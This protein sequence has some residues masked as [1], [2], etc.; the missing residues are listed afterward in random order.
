MCSHSVVAAQ[1]NHDLGLFVEWIKKAMKC[2][3]LAKLLTS[4]MSK[5]RGKKGSVYVPPRKR[6]KMQDV[7]ERKKFTEILSDSA[8][9]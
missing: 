2:P 1:D 7:Q 5:G 4:T 9:L 6:K 8:A 3:N